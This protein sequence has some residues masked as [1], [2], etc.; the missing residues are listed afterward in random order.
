[1]IRHTMREDIKSNIQVVL[2]QIN[3]S[4]YPINIVGEV[5]E[6]VA[7]EVAG[8]VVGEVTG[9]VVKEVVGV[10]VEEVVGVVVDEV[11]LSAFTKMEVRVEALESQISE[12]QSTLVDVQNS[13]TTNHANLIAMLEI[14]LGK[15]LM[16][17]E[18]DTNVYAKD[19]S[20]VAEK[21]DL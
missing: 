20:A 15:S 10:V 4:Q 14:Y 18:G 7:K 3:I 17:D 11:M 21:G 1:M 12:V 2:K 13:V 9:E 19:L 6:E 16:V 8:E 5:V